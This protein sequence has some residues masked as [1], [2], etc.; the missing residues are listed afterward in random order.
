MVA[1]N[2]P[3]AREIQK[4]LTEADIAA[5]FRRIGR[6]PDPDLAL[7]DF[8]APL[9]RQREGGEGSTDVGDVSWTVPTGG[10][11]GA[12]WVPGTAPHSWQAVAAGGMSIGEKGLR[13][14][15]DVLAMTA[16]D[17]LLDPASIAAA[18]ARSTSRA[19]PSKRQTRPSPSNR[20]PVR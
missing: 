16:V 14:A 4:T 6:T 5:T 8:V 15:T 12:S 17:L 10:L 18:R 7:C 9:D 13:I 11:S 2:N 20:H 3:F 1:G 19:Q